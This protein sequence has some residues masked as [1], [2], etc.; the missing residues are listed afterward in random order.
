M[1]VSDM[2]DSGIVD[3]DI[4]M[5]FLGDFLKYG[6]HTRLQH[7]IAGIGLSVAAIGGDFRRDGLDS[8]PIDVQEPDARPA[9]SEAQ[10][11]CASNAAARAGHDREVA[12]EA[13]RM[14]VRFQR[15]PPVPT[16]YLDCSW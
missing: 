6:V 2:G 10:R 3:Q 9:I 11:N 1:Q 12:V 7:D 8:G 4:D 14:R 5:P 15:K 13:K 16:R